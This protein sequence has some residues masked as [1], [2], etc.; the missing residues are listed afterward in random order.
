MQISSAASTAWRACSS[1]G[2][3]RLKPASTAPPWNWV[4]TPPCAWM[5]RA[6]SSKWAFS[7]LRI[8]PGDSAAAIC[9]KAFDVRIEHRRLALL[10]RNRAFVRDQGICN[11]LGHETAE[12]AP[13]AF[14]LGKRLHHLVEAR[15]Q[16]SQLVVRYDRHL[17]RQ[18]TPIHALHRLEQ[19]AHRACHRS[20]PP[21]RT[22]PIPAEQ[23]STVVGVG[24]THT[25]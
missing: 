12:G 2:A 6:T 11:L 18:I 15:A 20:T 4:I 19:G 17:R 5:M 24:I 25:F 23:N 1:S 10:R 3:G 13:D 7:M 9:V 14:A 8:S 22:P 16:R 21:A